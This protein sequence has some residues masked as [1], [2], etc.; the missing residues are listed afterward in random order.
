M[1]GAV[2]F[3]LHPG[4][5]A[6]REF[7]MLMHDDAVATTT[8][9]MW[10]SYFSFLRG[11][12]AFEGGSSIGAGKTFRKQGAPRQASEHLT[13]YIRVTAQSLE[14]AQEL[15]PGNPVFECGGTVEIRE[16]PRG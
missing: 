15:L 3:Q 14:A 7:I 16:L 13:G 10:A 12:G 4:D 8:S 5:S 2:L 1:D 11:R 6:M 9:E